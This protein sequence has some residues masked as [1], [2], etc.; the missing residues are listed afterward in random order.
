VR[1]D[2]VQLLRSDVERFC[3]ELVDQPPAVRLR[4]LAV[5]RAMVDEVTASELGSAMSSA[6]DEGWGLRRIAKFS[7]V[8][9]EQV[10]RMLAAAAEPETA[11]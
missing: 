11:E 2:G 10:R 4:S 3:G 7:D 1:L 9:H 5:L 8:S 6:R